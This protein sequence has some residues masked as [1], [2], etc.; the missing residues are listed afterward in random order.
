MCLTILF[1]FILSLKETLFKGN[2]GDLLEEGDK[3]LSLGC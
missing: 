1:K 2:I 3:E